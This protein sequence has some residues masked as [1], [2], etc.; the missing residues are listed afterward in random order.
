MPLV[1][2]AN[3]SYKPSDFFLGVIDLF[4]ILIP[5]A[6]AC[7]LFLDVAQHDIFNDHLLPQLRGDVPAAAAFLVAAYLLGLV[8]DALGSVSLDWLTDRLYRNRKEA[9][10]GLLIGRAKTIR[11]AELGS[12]E[13]MTSGFRWAR[14]S[15]YATSPEG[16][17]AVERLEASAKL[18][19]S[20][21][22]VLVAACVKFAVAGFVV[23][24]LVSLAVAALTLSRTAVQRWQRDKAAFEYYMVG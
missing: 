21:T 3:M 22:V 23:A 8:A 15:V 2:F 5:G 1:A 11:V 6:V 17:R 12:D 16:T 10:H 4:G 20:L 19:R 9:A 18:F 24:A 13:G 7:L 14:V